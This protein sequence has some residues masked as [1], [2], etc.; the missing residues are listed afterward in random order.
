MSGIVVI[1]CGG[2][3]LAELTDEFFHSVAGLN[4]KANTPSLFTVEDLI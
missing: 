2:S 3:T 4:K 1:K